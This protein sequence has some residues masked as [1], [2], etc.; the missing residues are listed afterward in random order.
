MCLFDW[1]IGKVFEGFE[2]LN[3]GGEVPPCVEYW[4]PIKTLKGVGHLK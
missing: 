2:A 3:C 4:P 1:P